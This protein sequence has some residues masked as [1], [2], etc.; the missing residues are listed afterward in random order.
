MLHTLGTVQSLSLKMYGTETSFDLNSHLDTT[1]HIP[2]CD[3]RVRAPKRKT[4]SEPG[5]Q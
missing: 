2:Q 3:V 4:M 1:V 5:K